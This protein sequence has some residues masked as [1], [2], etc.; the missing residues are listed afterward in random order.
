M[1]IGEEEGPLDIFLCLRKPRPKSQGDFGASLAFVL[2]KPGCGYT[3]ELNNRRI[4]AQK[5]SKSVYGPAKA[6]PFI[7]GSQ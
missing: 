4:S 5:Y 2:L 7:F 1:E 6:R 3:I